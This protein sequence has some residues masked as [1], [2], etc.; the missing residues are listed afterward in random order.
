MKD[1]IQ[2]VGVEKKE[3]VFKALALAFE[4]GLARAFTEVVQR[5]SF[6]SCIRIEKTALQ[7]ILK[8]ATKA[9]AAMEVHYTKGLAGNALVLVRTNDL[10]HLGGLITGTEGGI[11][12]AISP[13]IMETC[14]QFF[15][16]AFAEANRTFSEKHGAIVSNSAPRLINPDG[17]ANDLQPLNE[18]YEGAPCATFEFVVEPKIDSRVHLLVQPDLLQSLMKLLPDYD[19]EPAV[20][21]EAEKRR[22]MHRA[23][24]QLE[25]VSYMPT[26]SAPASNQTAIYKGGNGRSG[27]NWNIDLLL[28]VELPIVVTF[29]ESEMQ[30]K[31]VLKFGVGSVIELDKSVNDPVVIMVNQKPI[32]RGEVV[33]VDGNYG[34]RILEVESTA[35][36]LRS[37]G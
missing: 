14:L 20:M 27:A 26:T 15:A 37:L 17:Q 32:A 23:E 22:A 1:S 34:V 33:M 21:S 11:D 36:R 31:D 35:E 30:L 19:P 10:F 12:D 16:R 24:E 2:F 3:K 13:Q 5:K 7:A 9:T 8:S 29:G 4:A 18:V 25:S 6:T 28:D